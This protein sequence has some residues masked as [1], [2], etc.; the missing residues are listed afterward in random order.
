MYEYEGE[1]LTQEEI[2]TMIYNNLSSDPSLYRQLQDLQ[3][4]T[5]KPAQ[6]IIAEMALSTSQAFAVDNK[7]TS[8][9]TDSTWKYLREK[10]QDMSVRRGVENLRRDPTNPI[11]EVNQEGEIVGHDKDAGFM[12]ML[13]SAY[14]PA[15]ANMPGGVVPQIVRAISD[16]ISDDNTKLS[17]KQQEEMDRIDFAIRKNHGDNLRPEELNQKRIE[18]IE[19]LSKDVNLPINY[20]NSKKRIEDESYRLFNPE[21]GSGEIYDALVWHDE[22]HEPI[23]FAKL[24]EDKYDLDVK[25]PE[26]LETISQIAVIGEYDAANP[27]S[28][29]ARK[30]MYKGDSW[31]IDDSANAS[32]DDKFTYASNQARLR[33]SYEEKLVDP[34]DGEVKTFRFWMNETTGLPE[35]EVVE[36]QD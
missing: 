3:S 36:Q 22:Y 1:R 28:P 11:I 5:G 31:V 12:D 4:Y 16:Y 29:K 25:D 33:G 2:G 34:D 27:F 30:V 10:A 9:K 24:M 35:Y 15:E 20:Y 18:Y 19:E 17:A 14:N 23:T 21:A 13:A 8:V 26:D 7:K 32:V 6:Q